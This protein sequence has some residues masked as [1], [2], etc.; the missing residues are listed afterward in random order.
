[1]SPLQRVCAHDE[2]ACG[3]ACG[4]ITEVSA[5]RSAIRFLFYLH[6]ADTLELQKRVKAE[7]GVNAGLQGATSFVA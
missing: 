4:G 1:M 7:F 6:G 5:T 3:W 2:R